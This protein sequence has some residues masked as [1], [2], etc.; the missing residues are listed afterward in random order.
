M[1]LHLR[2]I[3]LVLALVPVALLANEKGT[4]TCNPCKCEGGCHCGE[5][6]SDAK[7]Y[8]LKGVVVDILTE[9]GALLVKHEAIEGYM[10]AMTMLF[11]VD[12]ATLKSAQKGQAITGTLVAHGGDFALEGVK[13]VAP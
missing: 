9:K 3:A 10:P 4:C 11:K 5:A 2:V 6:K 8:P 12:A 1:K 7:R 13:P